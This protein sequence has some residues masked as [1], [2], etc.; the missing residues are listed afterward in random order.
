MV[1]TEFGDLDFAHNYFLKTAKIDLEAKYK[2]YAGSIFMGGSH[3]AANGGAWM[4][5]IFG[6]GGVEADENRIAIDPRLCRKWRSLQFRL[7]YQGDAFRITITKT[8]VTIVP[9]STNTREHTLLV[10]GTRA[11]CRPGETVTLKYRS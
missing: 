10:A 2:V 4:T 9:L 1:A 8:S 11:S 3:P 5:A 6:F 7:A